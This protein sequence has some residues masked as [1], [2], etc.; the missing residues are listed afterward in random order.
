MVEY[1]R[2]EQPPQRKRRSRPSASHASAS[3]AAPST[4]ALSP[5]E[6]SKAL[7]LHSPRPRRTPSS[8]VSTGTRGSSGSAPKRSVISA[9]QQ[10]SYLNGDSSRL[11]GVAPKNYFT[12][13]P[14][15]RDPLFVVAEAV[16]T[17]TTHWNGDEKICD[18]PPSV[19]YNSYVLPKSKLDPALVAELDRLRLEGHQERSDPH[20]R[21]LSDYYD[22]QSA[23]SHAPQSHHQRGADG[24]PLST[25]AP[26][27]SISQVSGPSRRASS[28]GRHGTSK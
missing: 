18:D 22:A 17:V 20:S 24:V 10:S 8:H 9:A 14:G 26:R 6:N 15:R 5:S 1:S 27:H 16:Q 21:V 2:Y 4:S 13:G 12:S 11:R 19:E 25:V 7:V 3:T 28:H 23:L